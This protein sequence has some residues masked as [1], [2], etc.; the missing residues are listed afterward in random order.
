ML[1]GAVSDF[2]EEM[3]STAHS[4]AE[5]TGFSNVKCLVVDAADLSQFEDNSFS[6]ITCSAGIFFVSDWKR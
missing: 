2:S 3:V 4:A 5:Q 6:A 1:L